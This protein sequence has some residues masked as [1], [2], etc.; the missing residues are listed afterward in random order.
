MG[1]KRGSPKEKSRKKVNVKLLERK[2]AGQVTEPYR[3]MEE[4]IEAH[5]K[6]LIDAKI[7]IAWRFGWKANT[8]GHVTL[9]QAKKGSDLDREMHDHDFVILLNH[10]AWN[11][12]L[13]PDQKRALMDHELCHAEISKDQNGEPKIDENKRTVYRIRKHDIEEFREI[14]A[15]HGCYKED[16]EAFVAAANED[17]ARPLLK[18]HEPPADDDAAKK[19]AEFNKAQMAK[20]DGKPGYPGGARQKAMDVAASAPPAGVPMGDAKRGRGRPK[21]SAEPMAMAGAS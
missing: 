13:N 20:G 4:I 8:D 19:T 5:H 21:K 10:E 6:H 2:H 18:A 3:I 12:S 1:R 7:A 14:V 9:G 16:L 17:R 11:G 15:R